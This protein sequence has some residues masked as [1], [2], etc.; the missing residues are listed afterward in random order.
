M[1]DPA[2]KIALALCVLMGGVCAALLFRSDS[3]Q[4]EVAP[5]ASVK[6]ETTLL[7]V[8]A[9]KRPLGEHRHGVDQTAINLG[10]SPNGV[11][12]MIVV[13]PS[14]R[15][16]P[17]PALSPKYPETE[18]P[19]SV[20]WGMPMDR[21]MPVA[22][23]ADRAA[24]THRVADGDTL[25][26]LAERYLGTSARADEILAANRESLSDPKLLPIGIELKIPAKIH[27]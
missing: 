27:P 15:Q 13:T 6:K 26:S 7:H 22:A 16:E 18:P 5:A 3:S 1:M 2:V 10:E 17:P 23:M 14:D 8:R 20:H 24:Q 12:P 21:M 11:R 25:E 9:N 4:K 19:P